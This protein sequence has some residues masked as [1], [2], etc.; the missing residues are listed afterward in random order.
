MQ[1][2]VNYNVGA[3]FAFLFYYPQKNF[4]EE[5]SVHFKEILSYVIQVRD[6]TDLSVL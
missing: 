3:T 1:F 5:N 6:G 2:E 4:H